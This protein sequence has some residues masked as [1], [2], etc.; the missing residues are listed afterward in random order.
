MDTLPRNFD[1]ALA[2]LGL[3][4]PVYRVDEAGDGALTLHLPA[5]AVEW[6]PGKAEGRGKKA[7]GGGKKRGTRPAEKPEEEDFTAIPY[8]GP[9]IAR[10]LHAAGF[11]TCEDLVKATDVQLLEVASVSEFTLGKIREY[12]RKHYVFES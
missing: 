5:G 12:L 11:A 1:L 8:V 2:E 6:K 4:G 3:S 10:A 7:E 9:E